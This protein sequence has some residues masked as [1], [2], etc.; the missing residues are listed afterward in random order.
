MCSFQV[1]SFIA[2]IMIKPQTPTPSCNFP[3]PKPSIPKISDDG[4]HVCGFIVIRAIREHHIWNQHMKSCRNQQ[5]YCKKKKKK[6]VSATAGALIARALITLSAQGGSTAGSN[7]HSSDSCHV[8]R[9]SR[10]CVIN[11][12]PGLFGDP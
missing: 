7:N 5:P 4:V 6:W 12:L 10:N 1:C 11:T 2:Q 9:W 3:H 8:A